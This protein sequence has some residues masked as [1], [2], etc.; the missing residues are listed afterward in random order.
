MTVTLPVPLGR[1]YFHFRAMT[2]NAA[3]IL[4]MLPE[5]VALHAPALLCP[6]GLR[7]DSHV[8]AIIAS[9]EPLSH[10]CNLPRLYVSS[11]YSTDRCTAQSNTATVVL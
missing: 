8:Y 4:V 11:L 7:W 9:D 2:R 6:Q 3:K 10:G 1:I 5:S